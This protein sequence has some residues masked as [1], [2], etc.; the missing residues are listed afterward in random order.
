MPSCLVLDMSCHLQFICNAC[1][2]RASGSG[3][4]GQDIVVVDVAMST[5]TVILVI[6]GVG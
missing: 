5:E 4:R 3:P 6:G 1:R 2:R